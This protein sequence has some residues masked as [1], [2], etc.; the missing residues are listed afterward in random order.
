MTKSGISLLI[1]LLG[2][3]ILF[4]NENISQAGT[5]PKESCDIYFKSDTTPHQSFLETK[6]GINTKKCFKDSITK[7]KEL[8]IQ[9]SSVAG[10]SGNLQHKDIGRNPAWV[11]LNFRI[12]CRSGNLKVDK[13]GWN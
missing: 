9:D 13:D 3:L 2:I 8:C 4:I 7:V 5:S 12:N 10:Y 11:E 6:S 1:L